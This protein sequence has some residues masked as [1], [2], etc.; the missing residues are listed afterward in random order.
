MKRRDICQILIEI[1][2][3]LEREGEL[4]TN[5]ISLRVGSQWRTTQKALRTLK[6]LGLIKERMN[7]DNKRFIRF[8][9]IKSEN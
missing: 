3:L 8:Y 5:Q 4:S 1:K 7:K 2:K 9:R 6:I